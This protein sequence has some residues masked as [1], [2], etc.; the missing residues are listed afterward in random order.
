MVDEKEMST[1]IDRML[2]FIQRKGRTTITEVSVS[3]ALNP[4][5]V[6]HLA[7]I[8]EESG[9]IKVKYAL[10]DSGK[11]ELISKQQLENKNDEIDRLRQDVE[12]IKSL[13]SLINKDIEKFE[14]DYKS[15]ERDISQWIVEAEGTLNALRAK[16]GQDP[17][18]LK[19]AEEIERIARDFESRI[20]VSDQKVENDA[21]SLKER[22]NSFHKKVGDFK[23]SGSSA[24]K[25]EQPKPAGG[26]FS[27]GG[28]FG[29]K[30]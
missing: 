6:E 26:G 3:L 19:Q 16:N 22:F 24:Q 1:V 2:D 20:S 11:T 12:R 15:M 7:A 9:M 28:F 13:G 29:K 10:I 5:Q 14:S 30:N 25:T 23:S 18:S 27:I 17:S 8:L 4:S 21:K